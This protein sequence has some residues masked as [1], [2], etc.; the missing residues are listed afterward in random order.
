MTFIQFQ[1]H[2]SWKFEFLKGQEIVENYL[3][4][5]MKIS[6]HRDWHY[7]FLHAIEQLDLHVMSRSLVDKIMKN[8]KIALFYSKIIY[9]LM[10]L[11]LHLKVKIVQMTLTRVQGQ[12]S[13]VLSGGQRQVDN[14]IE[15]LLCRRE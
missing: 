3:N 2:R 7:V 13:R 6:F 5:L 14:T 15:F 10:L 4:Q 12:S 11:Y 9:G 1:G 8:S